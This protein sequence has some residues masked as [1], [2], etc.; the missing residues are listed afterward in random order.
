MTDP[1]D[2]LASIADASQAAR[3]ASDKPQAPAGGARAANL[4]G[5]VSKQVAKEAAA[6]RPPAA[7]VTSIEH[8]L[9]LEE[10]AWRT[11]LDKAPTDALVACLVDASE[12]FRSRVVNALDDESRIWIKQNLKLLTEV[13][14]ALRDHAREQVLAA[15]NRLIA[16]GV[17]PQP[18]TRKPRTPDVEAPAETKPAPHVPRVDVG[19]GGF[20]PTPAKGSPVIA[21][22]EAE[23]PA[24]KPARTADADEVAP[25]T[26]SA[27]VGLGAEMTFRRQ[28]GD[29]TIALVSEVVKVA[30]GKN[31]ADLAAIAGHLDQPL[32]VEGLRLIA[33]GIDAN[34]L[35][36][37]LHA[38][39]AELLAEY[40]RQLDVMREGLLAIR[41]G[42]GADEFR[43]RVER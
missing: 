9:G 31:P 27:G 41:F 19:F 34:E 32:L 43:R 38:A 6:A 26:S 17:I 5:Q 29:P 39:Q 36:T 10:N 42:E 4:I 20:S 23:K 2:L 11:F 14:P 12:A 8:L 15:A 1:D 3:S 13:T 24:A 18:G 40:S 16:T 35:A 22:P 33:Q 37:A 7:E 30:K 21:E 25:L 28:P